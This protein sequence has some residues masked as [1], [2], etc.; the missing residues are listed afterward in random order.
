MRLFIILGATT[1]SQILSFSGARNGVGESIS[2][3]GLA[4]MGLIAGMMLM[5]I[6]LGLFVEQG[7]MMLITLP[8]FIP[9]VQKL[10]GDQGLFGLTFLIC[11]PL[12]LLLSPPWLL[13]MPR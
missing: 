3:L 7:S 10:G 13:L 6:F 4:P 5:L 12:G 8:I 9:P 1:F 2:R 11:M